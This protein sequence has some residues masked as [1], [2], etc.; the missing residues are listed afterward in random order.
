[1]IVSLQARWL[2]FI[3]RRTQ[4]VEAILLRAERRVRFAPALAGV[5]YDWGD[6]AFRFWCWVS[7][8]RQELLWSAESRL[9]LE[10]SV[11]TVTRSPKIG[12]PLPLDPDG[13]DL[14]GNYVGQRGYGGQGG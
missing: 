6:D 5:L 1:M 14:F 3:I 10:A 4:W 12:P 2:Q 13:Y 11:A 9:R 8:E 7:R